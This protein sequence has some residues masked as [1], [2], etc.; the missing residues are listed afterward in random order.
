MTFHLSGV[1]SKSNVTRGVPRIEEILRLTKNP[2]NPS[3]TIHMK[4]I[5]ELEKDRAAQYAKMLEHT[6]LVDV[7]K[8]VQ[9]CFDP[10]DD[11][12]NIIDDNLL[13]D[14]YHEFEKMMEECIGE[15]V[16]GVVQKSKWI[17]RMELDAE[18]L[19]DKN[20][21]M[22]DIHF[23]I[24]NGHGANL[25]CIYSDYNSSN[26]V[27]RIR[28][29]SS[30]FNKNKKQKG[31]PDTLDQSDEIYML[32]NFQEV[33]LNNIVLRGI[34]GIKNVT[35]R[36]LQNNIIKEEG[37]YVQKDIWVLDTVGTNLM[38]IMALDYID[39]NR[40]FSNDIK[41][42]FD[43]LG[44]EA[45]RQIIYNEFVDVMEFSDVYIN[46]HH[47]SLL[48]DRMTSTKNMVSIFRSG[49]LNDN[50]GPISKATFEVHTEV[51]LDASRHAEIDYARGVSANV[52][53]GQKSLIGTNS[54]QVVLDIEKMKELDT[55]ESQTKDS[56]KEI[57]KLFGGIEDTNDLCSKNR[58]EINNNLTGI[59]RDEMEDCKDDGY[60]IG[61]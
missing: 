16:D 25:S 7:V 2:K 50:I 31:I 40:T 26:L 46:Y 41:E 59:K 52:M 47:L 10:A 49:I 22:D 14:Q 39:G 38:G 55:M 35:P 12:T 54:F 28:L 5:D 32:R 58:I 3:L 51:L 9:I 45:A 20:I 56:N 37:K 57:E 21:T 11:S 17:I 27:F 53:L 1:A 34:D 42:I 43:T 23:A 15:E 6:K 30:V 44:I 8:S 29:N 36:K 24:T 33:L 61:F 48:C 13:M 4:P 60:D 18:A 19:L